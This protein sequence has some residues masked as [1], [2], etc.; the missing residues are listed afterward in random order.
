M[1]KSFFG[2]SSRA[3]FTGMALILWARFAFAAPPNA[4]IPGHFVD[5]SEKLGIRFRQQASPTSKKY[6]LEAMG[7]GVALFDYDNDGR[8][9][10]F[11]SN[12]ARLND[13]TAKGSTPKK[14]N[15]KYWNRLFH[16][17]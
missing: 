7:S 8:L 9:D 15:A 10:I 12:G 1:T 17:K 2:F 16:Q 3:M 6:L 4:P 14:D 11:F 5:A 13:P